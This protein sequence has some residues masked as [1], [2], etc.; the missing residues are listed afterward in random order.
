MKNYLLQILI[1]PLFLT[2]SCTYDP[3]PVIEH[4]TDSYLTGT[5]AFMVNEGNFRAG[6]GSLSF[7]SYDSSKIFNDIF[8]DINRRV[9]GDIPYSMTISGTY[10]YIVV[11]NSG[12]IEIVKVHDLASVKTI[13]GLISPRYISFVAADKAYI[14]SLYSDS[15]AVLDAAT[16][17]I[18]GYIDVRH[19][20]ESIASI[21]T[22]AY[23]ARWT[24]DNKIMV[25]NTATDLV[26]D[27]IEV[28]MEPE[29]M[30]IDR[31][32]T[33]WV[34]CNGGWKRDHYAELVAINTMTNTIVK[35]F[36]FPSVNDSP[37]CLQIDGS[38]ENLYFLLNGVRIMSV[39]AENLPAQEFI[40][41]GSRNFYKLGINPENGDI[42]VTDVVDY[43]Q[44]GYV[45]MYKSDGAFIRM[46][47]ADIIPG[48]FCFKIEDHGTTD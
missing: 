45:L 24:G 47:Q 38:G 41:A 22:T 34:L 8:Y 32:E 1:L 37:T 20:S 14:S 42:F 10:G 27:S 25:V 29:S 2:V 33:L 23:I 39:N 46:M 9:L 28:G 13:I 26:T 40:P 5:G 3:N 18:K 35:R 44:K 12:K 4:P 31:F 11:N 21:Y 17:S 15:V 19:P 48:A 30:V 16:N 6:N 7:F 36:T 43:Q